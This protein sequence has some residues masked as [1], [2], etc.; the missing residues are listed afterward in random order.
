MA[1]LRK[2]WTHIPITFENCEDFWLSATLK[3]FYNISTRS[4]KCPCPINRPIIPDLCAAEDLSAHKHVDAII[5]K[6]SIKHSIRN[7]IIKKIS[8]NLIISLLFFHNR[9]LLKILIINLFMGI[10]L[11]IHFL[12]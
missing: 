5:G 11:Q 1:W 7:K 2:A 4:P 10:F 6:T 12:I 3:S 9:I 8:I